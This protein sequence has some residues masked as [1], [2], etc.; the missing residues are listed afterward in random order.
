VKQTAD[1]ARWKRRYHKWL[2]EG[3][4]TH[5][6]H[7]RDKLDKALCARCR[8]TRVENN[9]RWRDKCELENQCAN[10]GD[11]KGPHAMGIYCLDCA[12]KNYDKVMYR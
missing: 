5:C 11:P 12:Q 10:C 4:C 1:A 7:E 2:T 9:Q 3:K 6:G 8:K